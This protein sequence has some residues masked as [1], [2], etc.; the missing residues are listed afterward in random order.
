MSVEGVYD[1]VTESPMGEQK[2]VL[3]IKID[4]EN[5]VGSNEGAQ[6]SMDLEDGKV[7]GN[8]LTWTMNMTVP[9]PMTLQASATVD[10]DKLSGSVNAGAF[11]DMP[12]TG[13]RRS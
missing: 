4:G 1:C 5:I 2:S 10:G 7:D 13:T 3:T 11:G 6:G 12:M 9:M 8:S